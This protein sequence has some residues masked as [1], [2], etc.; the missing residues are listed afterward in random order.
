MLTFVRRPIV[1]LA[2]VLLT[3]GGVIAGVFLTATAASSSSELDESALLAY[4]TAFLAHARDVGAVIEGGTAETRGMKGAIGAIE[5][6]ELAGR[7][8]RREAE[9]WEAMIGTSAD[10]LARVAVPD[11]LKPAHRLVLEAY[12]TYRELA[13]TLGEAAGDDDPTAI[14]ATLD[15]AVALG[16][17]GDE[18]FDA[19]TAVIQDARRE[20][21]LG[22]SP[23]LPDPDGALPEGVEIH[24]PHELYPE[25]S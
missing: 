5:R 13:R 22:P 9:A 4:E 14:D 11:R 25:D 24:D 8:L 20:L 16:T 6:S 19:A 18:Q 3:L 1:L 23:D 15:R 21:G 12:A 2:A 10:R 17:R 7:E